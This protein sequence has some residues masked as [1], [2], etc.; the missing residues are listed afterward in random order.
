MQIRNDRAKHATKRARCSRRRCRLHMSVNLFA[1]ID[2]IGINYGKS[3]TCL[4]RKGPALSRL[5][6]YSVACRVGGFGVVPTIERC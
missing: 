5:S 3:R 2:R 6:G 1:V 4:S